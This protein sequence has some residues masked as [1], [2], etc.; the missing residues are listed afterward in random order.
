MAKRV[1]DPGT[2]SK[3]TAN[4]LVNADGSFNVKRVGTL[5]PFKDFYHYLV[6]I[7]WPKFL[8]FVFVFYTC[9]NTI[10]A[11]VYLVIGI[12]QLTGI[13]KGTL[14]D[15]F[16]NCFFFSAQSLT[17]VGYGNIAPITHLT[18]MIASFEA[19]LGVLNFAL[20]TGL[21]F[22]RFSKPTAKIIYSENALIAP[23]EDGKAIMF[24]LANKRNNV[25]IKPKATVV[26]SCLE[27]KPNG[28]SFRDYYAMPLEVDSVT[29]LPLSWTVVHPIDDKSPF[30]NKSIQQIKQEKGEIMVQFSAFDDTFHETIYSGHSYMADELVDNA[31]FEKAFHEEN[32]ITVLDLNKV[33]TYTKL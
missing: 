17:T 12:D 13:E 32:G 2:G 7:S 27:K 18:Q 1:Q 8:F 15:D 24:R 33:G 23:Y 22:G 30:F 28:E 29:A 11:F 26:Y 25:L 16:L 19:L 5:S 31:R 6:N 14:L 21:L 10:F 9:L 3:G 4:R 20:I